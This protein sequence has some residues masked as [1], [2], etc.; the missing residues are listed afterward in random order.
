MR[1]ALKSGGWGSSA[2]WSSKIVTR[3]ALLRLDDEHR[4]HHLLPDHLRPRRLALIAA[5]VPSTAPLPAAATGGKPLLP[6]IVLYTWYVD[7]LCTTA[8]LD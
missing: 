1:W 7:L 3:P 5:T 4:L 6:P 2:V 8:A